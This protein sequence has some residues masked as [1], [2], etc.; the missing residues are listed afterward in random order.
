MCCILF[1]LKKI[2]AK[3][4][5]VESKHKKDFSTTLVSEIDFEKKHD[6]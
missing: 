2:I 4:D 5:K 6:E 1:G 3:A